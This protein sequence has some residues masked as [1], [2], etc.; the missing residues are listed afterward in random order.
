L[1]DRYSNS[2]GSLFVG[3]EISKESYKHWKKEIQVLQKVG[4]NQEH[5]NVVKLYPGYSDESVETVNDNLN[6]I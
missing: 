6:I 4:R 1:I 2:D 3:K 5:E